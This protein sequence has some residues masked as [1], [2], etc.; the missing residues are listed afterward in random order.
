[1]NARL[2]S[3]AVVL[4]VLVVGVLLLD[5]LNLVRARSAI[6]DHTTWTETKIIKN[7]DEY[8]KWV[9]GEAD[10]LVIDLEASKL[11]FLQVQATSSERLKAY[12]DEGEA[13]SA[14]VRKLVAAYKAAAPESDKISLDSRSYTKTEAE[15]LIRSLTEL[16]D[17]NSILV[18]NERHHLKTVDGRLTAIDEE[19]HKADLLRIENR[20][21]VAML[22]GAG[23]AEGVTNKV[24]D[25]RKSLQALMQVKQRHRD[26]V[27]MALSE[28]MGQVKAERERES[29]KATLDRWSE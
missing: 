4:A 23:S 16:I 29:F 1:M 11:K 17:K 21:A 15:Q 18:E 2:L 7:P 9:E 25:L 8:L 20:T 14:F 6:V 19:L 10:N 3:V 26:S 13:M 5:P 28:E 22:R 12:T 24:S 27:E